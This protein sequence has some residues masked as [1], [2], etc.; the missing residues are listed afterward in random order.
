MDKEVSVLP[1]KEV[2]N[3]V[4]ANLAKG[5]EK[6]RGLTEEEITKVWRKAAGKLAG[7]KSRPTSLRKGKL[8]VV[9]EDSSL[10]YDL[11]LRKSKILDNLAKDLK[12]KIQDIQF[13]IG[14]ASGEE[15]EKKGRRTR[16]EGQRS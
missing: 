14:D 9:V 8:I 1:I 10:L 7:L 3:K 15:K 11:T 2:V 13:R 5:A 6:E 16:G 12:G 4:I